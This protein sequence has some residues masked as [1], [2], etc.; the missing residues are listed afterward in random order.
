MFPSKTAIFYLLFPLF[1]YGR[2]NPGF[3][4]EFPNRYFVETGSCIGSGIEMALQTGF[5]EIHSIELSPKFYNECR[6]KFAPYSHVHLWFGDSSVVLP[7]VIGEIEEPITFWL[8]GHWSGG[9]TAKGATN[10][11]LLEELKAIG[12]HPIKTHTL[13]IDDVRCFGTSHFDEI[14]LSKIIEKILEI[15]PDY[16]ISYRNGFQANDILVA[17]VIGIQ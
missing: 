3:F 10:T 16:L 9:E 15:N 13:L 8:D 11:P 6:E 1:L 2:A 7:E 4:S 5:S 14:P 12:N 17:Q